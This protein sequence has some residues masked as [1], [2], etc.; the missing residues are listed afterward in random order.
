MK[1][2]VDKY[3][4]QERET[5]LNQTFYDNVRKRLKLTKEQLPNSVIKEVAKLN[6]NLI[7]DWVVNNPDGF[8]IKNNGIL[9]VSKFMPKCLRGDKIETIE[10]LKNNPRISDY[11]RQ[12]YIDRYEKG[13]EY[14]KNWNT[15]ELRPHINLE[16]FLNIYKVMWFN[17]RNCD[18]EKARI[19]KFQAS[20]EFR[21]KLA[22]KIQEGQDYFD[23]QFS[24][25]TERKRD[26]KLSESQKQKKLS[27]KRKRKTEDNE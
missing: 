24:D 17:H 4:I 3:F 18:F 20:K 5:I 15:E 2:R 13:I 19:Y 26:K 22:R 27:K 7:Q 8:K 12:R 9:I 25:W 14:N 1:G 10:Q 16:T 6:N 23:W 21:T 11:H